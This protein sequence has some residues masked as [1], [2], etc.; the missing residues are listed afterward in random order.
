MVKN[1]AEQMLASGDQR[2]IIVVGAGHI[3]G[4]ME[5]FARDYPQIKVIRFN[6]TPRNR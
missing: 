2:S 1:V 4:M 6:D 3:Y 5:A